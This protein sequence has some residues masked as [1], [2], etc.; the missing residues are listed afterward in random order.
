MGYNGKA[1]RRNARARAGA[2][3][4]GDE[5]VMARLTLPKLAALLALPVLLAACDTVKSVTR[6]V[7]GTGDQA[8]DQ[9]SSTFDDNV[10]RPPLT[11]PPDFNLRPPATA[12]GAG[13]SDFTAAQQGRQTVFGLSSEN[14]AP[15]APGAA[16]APKGGRSLGEAAL[17]R[18]AGT[19][20]GGAAAANP[21]IRQKIDQESDTLTHQ[22]D[23][24]VNNLLNPP[25]PAEPTED[26][27]P[28]GAIFDKDKTPTIERQGGGLFGTLF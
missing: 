19:G 3:A 18:H 1:V 14:K 2:A 9:S 27:G 25:K 23:N 6:A 26:K 4:L 8:A 10:K 7:T 17:L 15:G 22:E 21:G 11:L 12:S 13:A 24:F 20:S 28:L 16:P 5:R